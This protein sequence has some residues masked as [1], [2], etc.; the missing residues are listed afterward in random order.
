MSLSDWSSALARLYTCKTENN[1]W[2]TETTLFYCPEAYMLKD[3]QHEQETLHFHKEKFENKELQKF[4]GEK[5]ESCTSLAAA[6]IGV[7]WLAM[8]PMEMASLRSF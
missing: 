5:Y 3:K 2:T 4:R 1:G 7:G 6:A 8:S